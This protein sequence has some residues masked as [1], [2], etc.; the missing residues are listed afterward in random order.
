[1]FA[2][3]DQAGPV[4]LDGELVGPGRGE[5]VPGPV[6]RDRLGSRPTSE[7]EHVVGAARLGRGTD[8]RPLP[9]A[10][11][12][13]AD[14]GAGDRP[15]DVGVADLDPV[16][17][18]GH[19]GRIQAVDPTREAVGHGVLHGDGLLEVGHP[20]DAEH[21]PEALGEVEPGSGPDA[22][23]H[24]GPPSVSRPGEGLGGHQPG[25]AVVQF[26]EGSGQRA[27]R[28]AD[29]RAEAGGGV[30]SGADRQ[31]ADGVGQPR[32][33]AWVR[34]TPTPRRGRGWPPSTSGRRGRTRTGP[35]RRWRRRG[36]RW[37]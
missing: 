13:A 25:L 12:L 17:P 2:S 33:E 27:R 8:A 15:V 7:G 26:A 10:E 18:V 30:R 37:R 9:A 21:G 35:G 4:V 36:R 11:G 3:A 34:R 20:H 16:Q 6:E 29:Q 1:M 28:R 19:L 14:D 32:E 22:R 5:G 24:A 31:A 23:A